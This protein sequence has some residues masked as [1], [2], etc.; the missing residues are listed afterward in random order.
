MAKSFNKSGKTKRPSSLK[1]AATPKKRTSAKAKAAG[2]TAAAKTRKSTV[3]FTAKKFNQYSESELRG[4]IAER[5]YYIY[6]ENGFC[7]GQQDAHWYQAES[8]VLAELQK[9]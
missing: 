8:E 4:R 5:A 9:S 3:K 7:D 6:A 1:L 2:K